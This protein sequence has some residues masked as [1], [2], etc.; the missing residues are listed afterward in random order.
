M[1]ENSSSQDRTERSTPQKRRRARQEGQIARSR[2]LTTAGLFLFGGFAMSWWAPVFGRFFAEL[3]R[4]QLAHAWSGGHNGELMEEQLGLALWQSFALL[5]PLFAALAVLLVFL[6]MVPGGFILVWT[7]LLPK[8]NR[9]NPIAGLGRMF[10][11]HGVVE[12]LK[13]LLK[14]SL[15]GGTLYFL[16]SHYW[17]T[18]RLMNRQ[19][20]QVSI[21]QGL[22]LLALSFMSMGGALLF[23]AMIDAPFQYWSLLRKLRMTKQEVR[24]EHKNTEGRPEVK[25]RIRQVQMAFARARIQQR[26]PEADLI[27]VN[28]TH[29]AVAIKYDARKA[30]APYVIAKGVDAMAL[31]I[32]EVAKQY[33]KSVL[34]LPDLT[35]AVYYSTRIDQEIPAG[36]YTAVAYVLTHVLQLQAYRRGRARKP[37]PLPALR[38]PEALRR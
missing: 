9:L 11:W 15:I 36:L 31:K 35:R 34:E 32:R 6:G 38:I 10:S 26:V 8:F 13:S 28:P 1:A 12:M 27:I 17:Q 3:M 24:E 18:L 5:A 30:S 16:L 29:Y 37:A 23:I 20:L 7:T 25:S 19:P 22:H 2:E 33:D 4:Y 14:I 21:E